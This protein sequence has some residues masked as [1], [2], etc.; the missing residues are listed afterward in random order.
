M[1]ATV[2]TVGESDSFT[3][4]VLD[5]PRGASGFVSFVSPPFDL[6][7]AHRFHA[8]LPSSAPHAEARRLV[9]EFEDEFRAALTDNPALL[10][11]LFPRETP[12]WQAT[13]YELGSDNYIG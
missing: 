13:A 4:S 1:L 3:T 12:R 11:G 9:V 7:R 10:T 6:R 2:R 5:G 8:V